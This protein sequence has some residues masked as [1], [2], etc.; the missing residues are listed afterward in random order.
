MNYDIKYVRARVFEFTDLDTMKVWESK[1]LAYD[2]TI[3][4]PLEG[5]EGCRIIN[6]I[7]CDDA[8]IHG[9]FLIDEQNEFGY[10]NAD[11]AFVRFLKEVG[12]VQGPVDDDDDRFEV[13]LIKSGNLGDIP[14]ATVYCDTKREAKKVSRA[15]LLSVKNRIAVVECL[16]C[17]NAATVFR[18]RTKFG[19]GN[20][21]TDRGVIFQEF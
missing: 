12:L 3:V 11:R 8:S 10:L 7:D 18:M 2:R 1:L 15:M 5:E 13:A 14:D 6:F 16:D 4:N 19:R 20:T 17:K 21:A 9:T